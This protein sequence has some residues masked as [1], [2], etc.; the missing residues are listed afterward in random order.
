MGAWTG[1]TPPLKLREGRKLFGGD[2]LHVLEPGD[3]KCSTTGH[4]ES[5]RR[6]EWLV[7]KSVTQVPSVPSFVVKLLTGVKGLVSKVHFG[8][9]I[10]FAMG[11]G[12]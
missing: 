7:D 11:E 3:T 2:T 1:S 12:S 9:C 4:N 10:L 8:Y 5:S 6:V